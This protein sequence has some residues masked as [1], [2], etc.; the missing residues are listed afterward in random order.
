MVRSVKAQI[1]KPP[2]VFQL[3]VH[4]DEKDL[5][6]SIKA[7]GKCDPKKCWH[8]MAI[9]KK[10]ERRAPGENHRVIV[11][12][13]HAR[14]HYKGWR[15]IADQPQ[16]VKR[17][18][19]LFDK[20]RYDLLHIRNYKLQFRRT[21]RV[22]PVPRERQDQINEARRQRIAA[23]GNEYRRNYP[24]MKKRVEGFAMTY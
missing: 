6:Y 19:L 10:M 17:S 1:R 3:E 9:H 12:A 13:G 16:H 11:D 23:G 2:K 21:T 14:L 7:G 5:T 8:R 18:I 20:E 15:Y 22:V 24:N 4:P